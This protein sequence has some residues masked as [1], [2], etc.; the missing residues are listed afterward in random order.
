MALGADLE[1]ATRVLGA[2]GRY[3]AQL[4]DEWEIWGPNGGYLAAIALRAAGKVAQIQRP[5]SFYCHF[6]SSPSFEAV[7]LDVTVLK[8][9]RRAESLQVAMTQEGRQI[10]HALVKTTADGP[11][12]H[13]RHL[14]APDVASPE[15]LK[16]YEHL[17]SAERRPPFKFWHNLERRPID[18]TRPA[19]PAE[20]VLREWARFR[21]T[22]CFDDP[23]VDASRALILLD[24]YGFPAAFRRFRSM[25]YV[26]P[27]LD[28]SAWFH[29]FSPACEWLLIDHECVVAEAGLMGVSGKVWDA[30]G[31]LLAT[32]SAHLCCIPTGRRAA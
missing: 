15:A 24:T 20:P 8:Q 32:G 2:D 3:V 10:L 18:Q 13:D 30:G 19:G 6:L 28:T 11:G 23:F 1:R 12:H 25:E 16:S 21:P 7:Q 14:Q 27:N 22:A 9:G 4:S 5:S 31:R 26:A 29:G 17:T